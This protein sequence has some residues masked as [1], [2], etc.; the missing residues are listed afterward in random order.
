MPD[1]PM[2]SDAIGIEVGQMDEA[3]LP[4]PDVLPHD[5]DTIPALE[6]GKAG[7]EIDVVDDEQGLAAGQLDDEALVADALDIVTQLANDDSRA[8]NLDF[9]EATLI[10][11]CENAV[12]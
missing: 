6:R 2:E 5:D 3:A 7:S 11:L 4:T 8:A 10:C 12:T 1:K 9:T